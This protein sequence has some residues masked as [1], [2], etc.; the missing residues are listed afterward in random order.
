[1]KRAFDIRL[2]AYLALAFVSFTIIGTLSHEAGHYCAARLLGYSAEMNYGFTR[3]GENIPE[4]D[5][6]II[7]LCGPLQ[8]M[9]TGTTGFVLLLV[10]R[11][12]FHSAVRLSFRQWLLIFF[13]LFWLRELFNFAQGMLGWWWRGR[14]SAH[15][16]EARLAITLDLPV[17]GI[18]LPA[19]LISAAI[20]ALVVFRFIP[21]QQRLTF[22]ASGIAGGLLG[23]Y[24]WFNL[25]GPVVMS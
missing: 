6:F 24:C 5:A 21:A 3:Y 20:V 16:D 13:S 19:A 14:F 12:E 2:F 10:Y 1:M 4:A 15:N 17:I 22:I 9:L 8:T 11:K 23:F 25:I 7:T 18:A